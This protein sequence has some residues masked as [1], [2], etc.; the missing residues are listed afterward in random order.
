MRRDMPFLKDVFRWSVDEDH[1]GQRFASLSA[2][3][4][5]TTRSI[6]FS[7]S[8]QQAGHHQSNDPLTGTTTTTTTSPLAGQGQVSPSVAIAFTLDGNIDAFD[9]LPSRRLSRADGEGPSRWSE[10]PDRGYEL[11]CSASSAA[12]GS[13]SV[14]MAFF[15]SS[16]PARKFRSIEA[17]AD[18]II[19]RRRLRLRRRRAN[20]VGAGADERAVSSAASAAAARR[21]RPSG[22][23]LA[24]AGT[25]TST[26]SKAT[27]A[28]AAA[29]VASMTQSS[30]STV[31]TVSGV[32]VHGRQRC[33]R[34]RRHRRMSDERGQGSPS[35]S[36]RHVQTTA[37]DDEGEDDDDSF[38]RSACDAPTLASPS[39]SSSPCLSPLRADE[40]AHSC[41]AA[42]TQLARLARRS[43]AMAVQAEDIAA[44]GNMYTAEQGRGGA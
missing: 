2:A 28:S 40:V 21:L 35:D 11:S 34:R 20:G 10:S 3:N 13:S 32:S 38:I 26:P 19:T 8:A 25:T 14:M 17:A 23:W 15:D 42:L 27:A 22:G 29:V 5:F 39:S 18:A 37:V 7:S 36:T 33:R 1:E 12:S 4:C 9:S 30:V 43:D 44:R 24:A 41:R 16:S 6:R 31:S